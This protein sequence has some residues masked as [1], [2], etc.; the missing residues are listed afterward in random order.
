VLTPVDDVLI[1]E[2]EDAESQGHFGLGSANV[3][4]MDVDILLT[5]GS[6]EHSSELMETFTPETGASQ[7]GELSLNNGQCQ[8]AD[9]DLLSTSPADDFLCQISSETELEPVIEQNAGENRSESLPLMDPG[10]SS[11]SEHVSD[12]SCIQPDCFLVSEDVL[13]PENMGCVAEVAEVESQRDQGDLISTCEETDSDCIIEGVSGS[14]KLSC[15]PPESAHSSLVDDHAYCLSHEPVQCSTVITSSDEISHEPGIIFSFPSLQSH[16]YDV[17]AVPP[18]PSLITNPSI[19]EI[20]P[21]GQFLHDENHVVSNVSLLGLAGM[22]PM[23]TTA[24]IP[25]SDNDCLT[26]HSSSYPVVEIVPRYDEDEVDVLEQSDLSSHELCSTA[27]V[28]GLSTVTDSQN[29]DMASSI[30]AAS[31][32][33]SHRVKASTL[34]SV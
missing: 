3:M 2:T 32:S 19:D 30:V 26:L 14:E 23:D 18:F 15:W 6:D 9:N 4:N 22:E 34:T 7:E 8:V 31:T 12:T 5:V 17:T 25:G 13:A 29:D 28:S 16:A 24:S 1:M 10:L 21:Y 33:S 11:C 20:S 27:H